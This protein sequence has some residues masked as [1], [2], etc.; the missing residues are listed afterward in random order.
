MQGLK[1]NADS[2]RILA[3]SFSSLSGGDYLKSKTDRS[4]SIGNNSTFQ[5]QKAA[6]REKKNPFGSG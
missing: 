3:V 5:K 1:I 4:L 6:L 2:M